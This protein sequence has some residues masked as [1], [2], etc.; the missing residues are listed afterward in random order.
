MGNSHFISPSYQMTKIIRKIFPVTGLLAAASIIIVISIIGSLAFGLSQGQ[1]LLEVNKK[2]L[3][4]YEGQQFIF[5]K[6]QSPDMACRHSW[7][8]MRRTW[9][10]YI[11]DV[12]F[13]P[14]KATK[15]SCTPL[16]SIS[17]DRS[18]DDKSID[19]FNVS[20]E[21]EK[22]NR[23]KEVFLKRLG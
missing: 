17:A 9:N 13:L 2:T 11:I 16:Q 21:F 14:F 18:S 8:W 10:K 5:R 4:S 6:P 23:G 7:T 1:L 12:L 3:D 20:K 19:C 22:M 15:C